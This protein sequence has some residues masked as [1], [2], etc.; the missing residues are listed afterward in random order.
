MKQ[1]WRAGDFHALGHSSKRQGDINLHSRLHVNDDVSLD[2]RLKSRLFDG[3]E[4]RADL[5]RGYNVLA[6]LIR[7]GCLLHV[8]ADI[9]YRDLGSRNSGSGLVVNRSHNRPG[10]RQL[11]HR[12]QG[13]QSGQEHT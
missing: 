5:Q 6:A 2:K 4:V 12:P 3:Q 9:R 11:R 10:I 8:C 1:G 7:Q 13:S